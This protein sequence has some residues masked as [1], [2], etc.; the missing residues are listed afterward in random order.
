MDH[1]VAA[2]A[3]ENLIGLQLRAVVGVN[4]DWAGRDRTLDAGDKAAKAY[5]YPCAPDRASPGIRLTSAASSIGR[6]IALL[7]THAKYSHSPPRKAAF[8][9]GNRQT[10]ACGARS[11]RMRARHLDGDGPRAGSAS[12]SLDE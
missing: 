11:G 3:D 6:S 10:S 1:R 5:V 2:S 8:D 4:G 12:G 7:G 9:H